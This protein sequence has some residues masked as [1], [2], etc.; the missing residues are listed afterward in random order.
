[1]TVNAN[2][3]YTVFTDSVF[4]TIDTKNPG[5]ILGWALLRLDTDTIIDGCT[6]KG[7]SYSQGTIIRTDDCEFILVNSDFVDPP[8]SE[9]IW[10]FYKLG[11]MGG[12]NITN[13]TF[14]NMWMSLSLL[15]F[16]NPWNLILNELTFENITSE[17]GSGAAIHLDNVRN[18]TISNSSFKEC[19]VK[20]E[21]GVG[22]AIWY[23][24]TLPDF[25]F[26][27]FNLSFE[28]CLADFGWLIYL[29][30]TN[31][32]DVVRLD[33]FVSISYDI[34]NLNLFYGSDSINYPYRINMSFVPFLYCL[35]SYYNSGNVT[36]PEN[37]C[38]FFKEEKEEE[39]DMV[40][41]CV[42]DADCNSFVKNEETQRC[43]WDC[44]VFLEGC[45]RE[46]PSGYNSDG[47]VCYEN[48]LDD[49]PDEDGVCPDECY[50]EEGKC[51]RNCTENYIPAEDGS[52]NCEKRKTPPLNKENKIDTSLLIIIIVSGVVFLALFVFFV[53]LCCYYFV[54]R[55]RGQYDVLSNSIQS[56]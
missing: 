48:C 31:M 26:L 44:L 2:Q 51:V 56:E 9:V 39:D 54:C 12:M 10:Y 8:N 21:K 35:E 22:G 25:N 49:M 46:C 15:G 50:N 33:R 53:L 18:A 23:H 13:C 55:K 6:F 30:I 14:T 37:L 3:Y 43:P 52:F 17:S 34:E 41:I 11:F 27:F 47:V 45:I 1:M 4:Y 36:C 24:S 5:G 19:S 20:E 16:V 32:T 29:D 42:M 7:M 40:G 28:S 38:V